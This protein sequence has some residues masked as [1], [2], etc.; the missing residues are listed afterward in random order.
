[1]NVRSALQLCTHVAAKN[2]TLP[3]LATVRLD[4]TSMMATDLQQQIEIPIEGSGLPQDA[5]FCVAAARLARV[6]K[7]LPDESDISFRVKG[8]KLHITAGRTR[9]ELN[10]LPAADFPRL[11][12]A[13]G[14]ARVTFPVDGKEIA[15]ALA[16]VMPAMASGDIRYY[17]NGLHVATGAGA[18]ILTATDGHRLHR[19]RVPLDKAPDVAGA[20][21]I[22]PRESIARIAELAEDHGTVEITLGNAH[23]TLDC[24][25]ALATK[26]IDGQFPDADRVIPSARPV[27]ATV[28]CRELAAAARRV[29]PILAGELRGIRLDCNRERIELTAKNG[30]GEIAAETFPWTVA[31]DKWKGWCAGIQSAFLIEALD[32][33]T[34]DVV[35]LHL[36]ESENDSLYI[37][38]GDAGA[39]QVVVMPMRI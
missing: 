10:T 13:A 27:T 36:T 20:I 19:I 16:F 9:Y 34:T 37:T 5:P 14:D 7:V 29:S 6:L 4:A 12:A 15:K 28:N 35:H 21:G 11:T 33:F 3:V 26:L 32:A 22:V 2:A 38:D 25:E 23:F 1:M 39:R 17:L 24:E 30:D 18:V 31:G 8:T